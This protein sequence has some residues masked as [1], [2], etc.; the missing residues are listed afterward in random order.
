MPKPKRAPAAR[1]GAGA[2]SSA[3]EE[4]NRGGRPEHQPTK[5][6]RELVMLACAAGYTVVQICRV[7]GIGPNTLKKHYRE[8]LDEG[9]DRI[10]LKI[11]GNIVNTALN[12]NHPKMLTAA[13]WFT[14]ARMGWGAAR[15][16]EPPGWRDG[17]PGEGGDDGTAPVVVTLHMGDRRVR[18]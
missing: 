6:S 11:A 13:I 12:P 2:S 17:L 7:M 1:G 10:G 15:D 3:P 8:E 16:A 14:R 9:A 18:D 5:Q 4:P